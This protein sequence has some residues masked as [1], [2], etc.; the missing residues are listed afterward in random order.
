MP[1]NPNA[2]IRMSTKLNLTRRFICVASSTVFR[3]S[4]RNFP[5]RDG[6]SH[7]IP[8]IARDALRSGHESWHQPDAVRSGRPNSSASPPEARAT[9]EDRQ[10]SQGDLVLAPGASCRQSE[11]S[12]T[13]GYPE[14]V[15]AS[16]PRKRN[17]A[18]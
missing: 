3:T 12:A 4:L 7:P 6:E 16:S 13:E 11:R 14:R 1:T 8:D 18:G 5:S 17:W 15:P 9:V 2:K 10:K